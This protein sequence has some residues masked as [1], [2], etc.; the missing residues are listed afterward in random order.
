M[1]LCNETITVINAK[2]TG[3]QGLDRYHKTVI[4]G[5]ASEKVVTFPTI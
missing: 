5:A 4:T 2:Q 3:E 1:K